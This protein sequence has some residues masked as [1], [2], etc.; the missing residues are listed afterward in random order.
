MKRFILVILA[1]VGMSVAQGSD[2]HT[3]QGFLRNQGGTIP[4]AA[5][6]RFKTFVTGNSDTLRYPEDYPVTNYLESSGAWLA[7]ISGLGYD[8][9][10]EFIIIFANTCSSYSGYDTAIVDT[11]VPGQT[12][13]TT[14]VSAMD[15]MGNSKLP[16]AFSVSVSP[17]PFNGQCE[18]EIVGDGNITVEVF[19]ALGQSIGVIYEGNSDGLVVMKWNPLTCPSGVYFVRATKDSLSVTKS[20]FYLQ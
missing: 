19:N 14:Y 8:D 5:C 11:S 12:I 6:V 2:P 16:A 9:G 20:V 3:M 17:M 1:L 13:G 7:Q 15:I 10:D 4:A 18:I